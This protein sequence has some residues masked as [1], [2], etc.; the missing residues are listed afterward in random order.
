MKMTK[1][2]SV[3]AF[4]LAMTLS[5]V[6]LADEHVDKVIKLTLSAVGSGNNVGMV[7][8]INDDFG[9]DV[10]TLTVRNMPEN[11]RI[12]VLLTESQ[13][14]SLLPVQLLGEFTT[15]DRG[16]GTLTVI[17]EVVGAFDSANQTLEDEFGVALTFGAGVLTGSVLGNIQGSANTTPLDWVRA[18]AI[19]DDG[20]GF[21]V[22]G[23]ADDVPGGAPLF[24]S[25]QPLP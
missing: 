16:R 25:D 19:P 12:A 5:T 23:G 18:Y 9:P 8:V 7:T 10:F 17:T 1:I 11:T 3:M 22:F 13:T 21:N 14:F 20:T 24:S 6:T 15:N 2:C 4:S